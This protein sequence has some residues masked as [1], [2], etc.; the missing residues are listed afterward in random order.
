MTQYELDPCEKYQSNFHQ[1]NLFYL[2]KHCN[3]GHKIDKK[4]TK[5]T[6]TYMP[7]DFGPF[8]V[9]H[10]YHCC[11][12]TIMHIANFEHNFVLDFLFDQGYLNTRKTKMDSS[13]FLVV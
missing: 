7:N 3:T 4:K 12:M 1:S 11:Q 9:F 2:D 8:L 5:K 10:S 13:T 6:G